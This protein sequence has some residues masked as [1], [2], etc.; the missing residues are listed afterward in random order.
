M[1]EVTASAHAYNSNC[2]CCDV[3]GLGDCRSCSCMVRRSVTCR[4]PSSAQRTST[5]LQH[6]RRPPGHPRS[7]QSSRP[8]ACSTYLP[9]LGLSGNKCVLRAECH[10]SAAAGIGP[11][12]SPRCTSAEANTGDSTLCSPPCSAP[13]FPPFVKF[14]ATLPAGAARALLISVLHS[15]S[16]C[17]PM[18]R[19]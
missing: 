2:L 3:L 10:A 4:W 13:D 9:R 11:R 14:P 7:W 8:A 18:L 16:L 5:W 6:G 15:P 19:T 12:S 1:R 17:C